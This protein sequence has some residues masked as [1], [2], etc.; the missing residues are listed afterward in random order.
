M[1]QELMIEAKKLF[2]SQEKWNSFLDLNSYK[3]KIIN[4]WYDVLEKKIK[5]HFQNSYNNKAWLFKSP[6]FTQY[7]WFLK[8]YENGIFHLVRKLF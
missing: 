8:D 1:S 4:E 6:A 3:D 5:H 7:K 2:D